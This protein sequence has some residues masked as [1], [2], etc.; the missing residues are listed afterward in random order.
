[1][2]KVAKF[3]FVILTLALFFGMLSPESIWA[4]RLLPQ[5]NQ[6]STGVKAKPTKGVTIKVSFRADRK[7]IIAVFSNL[8]I[9]K[10][11]EYSLTYKTNGIGQAV[12]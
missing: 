6:V 1:M 3:S 11:V 8:K 5:A 12:V 4:K 7:A 9:A 2:R 10:S